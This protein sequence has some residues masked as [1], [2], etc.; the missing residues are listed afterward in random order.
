M[1]KKVFENFQYFSK[2]SLREN[3]MNFQTYYIKVGSASKKKT[4]N[5]WKILENNLEGKK[6]CTRLQYPG[7]FQR[8]KKRES[9]IARSFASSTECSDYT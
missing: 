1:K 3:I 7:L 9:R 8:L 2:K 6:S 5:K 4:R